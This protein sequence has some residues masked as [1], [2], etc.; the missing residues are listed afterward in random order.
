MTKDEKMK[1]VLVVNSSLQGA[2]GNSNKLTEKFLT[3]LSQSIKVET[4]QIDLNAENL[5]HL[6]GEEMA[7]WQVAPESRTTEEKDLALWSE[8]YVNAV[9]TSDYIVLGVPMYNFDSPS[10]LKA[11]FDRIARAGVTFRYTENGPEG[12]LTGKKVFVLAARGGK[13]AGTDLDTQTQYLT[14]FLAFLGMN[15]VSFVYAEGLAMGDES[16]SAAFA[17]ASEKIVEL[18]ENLED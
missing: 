14:N 17:S 15:D 5:P 6:S 1:K 9:Q 2:N 13:Y 18:I 11:F 10:V 12:L 7:S 4:Q 3:L 8:R 16:A